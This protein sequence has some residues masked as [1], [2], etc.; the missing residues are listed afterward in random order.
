MSSLWAAKKA[1]SVWR[2]AIE[3]EAKR[4]NKSFDEARAPA[5]DTCFALAVFDKMWEL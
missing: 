3:K 5:D 2:A 4:S 1:S